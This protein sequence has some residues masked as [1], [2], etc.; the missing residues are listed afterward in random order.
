[1][2]RQA[3]FGPVLLHILT[4]GKGYR[5]AEEQP[6]RFHGIGPFDRDTGRTTEHNTSK[7]GYSIFSVKP[8][9]I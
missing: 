4:Q 5:F 9:W 3:G 1:M 6:C 2:L 7:P 8:F